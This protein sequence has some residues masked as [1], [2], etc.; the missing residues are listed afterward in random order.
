MD[1]VR[2]LFG[3]GE[4]PA[5]GQP[6][7]RAAGDQAAV[8]AEPAPGS[9][10]GGPSVDPGVDEETRDR[11]LLR[12]EAMRLNDELLQRQMRYAD[13]SWTPPTQGGTRRSG[14]EDGDAEDR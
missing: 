6:A 5:G 11:E 8:A 4:Q 14:D 3:G 9:S 1:F 12:A 2:R 7:G 13:R 10:A